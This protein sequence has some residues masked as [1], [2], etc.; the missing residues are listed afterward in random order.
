MQIIAFAKDIK[1]FWA[2][3]NVK[4]KLLNIHYNLLITVII[5]GAITT[6]TLCDI[7]MH[8]LERT[9]KN[10][11]SMASIRKSLFSTLMFYL[12]IMIA[13]FWQNFEVIIHILNPRNISLRRTNLEVQSF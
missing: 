2:T 13:L 6:Y 8:R 5:F 10:I 9:E 12:A 3:L 4:E 1:A 11:L 7:K